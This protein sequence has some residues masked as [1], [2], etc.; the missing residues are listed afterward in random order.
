MSDEKPVLTLDLDG[1]IC[2]PLAALNLGIS[3]TFLDPTR[4]PVPAR[5]W[6]R[7]LGGPLDALRFPMRRP[8]PQV[9]AALAR[10]AAYRS[11]VLLTGR[12][13]DPSGWLERY[14]L[15]GHID[16]LHYNRGPL[17][18]P[19]FKLQMIEAI[20][21]AEHIDD[22]GRTA[23]LLAE[24]SSVRSYL[25]DWP[26]NRGADYAPTV[27]RVDDLA[28]LA[29]VIAGASLAGPRPRT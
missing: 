11:L 26:R 19:H 23:Q 4:E 9:A 18:S 12:R 29:E 15:T 8:L 1:V 7:W 20:G 2:G 14:G 6:P 17:R 3:Q 25:R 16:D 5:V 10:L 22:D 27:T 24:T 21:A 13:S 28:A